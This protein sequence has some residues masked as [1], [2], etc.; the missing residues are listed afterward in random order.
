METTSYKFIQI[1]FPLGVLTYQVYIRTKAKYK[2]RKKKEEKKTQK[3]QQQKTH[4][5][6]HQHII[7]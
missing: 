3:K 4:K 5:Y 7:N 1:S 2:C 6:D